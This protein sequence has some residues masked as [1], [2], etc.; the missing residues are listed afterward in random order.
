[1]QTKKPKI[2][3]KQVISTKEALITKPS[4]KSKK[5]VSNT[6]G[7]SD[8]IELEKKLRVKFGNISLLQQSLTHRSFLN[9]NRDNQMESN[10]RLEFLG[11]AILSYCISDTLYRKLPDY[12][13]G[14]LTNIRSNL[15]KTTSLVVI[16]KE[17]G[18]GDYLRLSHGEADT[19]GR[20]NPSLLA[21]TIE[22]I[23]GAIFIDQ[24][25]NEVENFIKIN[26]DPVFDRVIKSGSFKDSKSLLQEKIQAINNNPPP[27]Y[28]VLKE[29]GPDHQK[30][31]TVGVYLKNELLATA[32]GK[33][34]REAEE[35]SARKSLQKDITETINKLSRT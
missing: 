2:P 32:E 25:L 16:A 1:M 29:E 24:G 12:P 19:G 15:V 6:Q 31:F 27:I 35:E 17:L 3:N 10:E 8:L 7:G 23:I 9:E 28:K 20:Q 4:L 30:T 14:L 34:K 11:D 21:D 22:A 13:E 5:H 26:F 18:I 33:S